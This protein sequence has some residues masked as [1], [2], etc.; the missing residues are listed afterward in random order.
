MEKT[1]MDNDVLNTAAELYAEMSKRSLEIR[2]NDGRDNGLFLQ[3]RMDLGCP[4]DQLMDFLREKDFSAERFL[5]AFL[6]VAKPFSQMFADI[7]AYLSVHYAPK[8]SETVS[9]RFGFP[10]SKDQQTINL[11]QFRRYTSDAQLIEQIL[12]NSIWPYEAFALLFELAKKLIGDEKQQENVIHVG[13][14]R[15]DLLKLPLIQN[16]ANEMDDVIRDIRNLFQQII[17]EYHAEVLKTGDRYT[18]SELGN[19]AS[20]LIDLVPGWYSIFLN[21]AAISD[22]N[23]INAY[24]FYSEQIK[25][26]IKSKSETVL[27]EVEKALEI[28]DLPFWKHRWHTYEIWCTVTVLKALSNFNPEPRIVDGRIPFDGY[29]CEVIANLRETSYPNS[30]IVIQGQTSVE[31]ED[32]KAMRPDLRVC[33]SYAVDDIDNTA[34]VVEFKQRAAITKDH[35]EEVARRYTAGTPNSGGTIIINYDETNL[36][37]KLPDKSYYIEGVHP[38]NPGQIDLFRCT[39]LEILGKMNLK[40]IGNNIVL[41][42]I[43]LSMGHLYDS[44]VARNSLELCAFVKEVELYFFNEELREAS[45]PDN[46]G[47]EFQ[48][49]GGTDLSKSLHQLL[50]RVGRID[51]L[52]IVSDKGYSLPTQLLTGIS[53]RECTPDHMVENLS[54]IFAF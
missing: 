14:R 53:F 29:S 4:D 40:K 18:D 10:D 43:S 9:I 46:H 34:A 23:K 50:D 2:R 25:P 49:Y 27:I 47:D 33:F 54:W 3:L 13:Y 38:G 31:T 51:R 35:I 39:L 11:E 45:L 22:T 15:G 7:W 28:L 6:N 19:A 42:D 26:L 36:G 30:C 16:S 20:A 8:T 21:R 52:L 24:N 12:Q 32:K 37:L 41:V 1:T 48:T 17:D 44:V 5:V